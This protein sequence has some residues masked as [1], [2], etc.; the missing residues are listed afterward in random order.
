MMVAVLTTTLAITDKS[1]TFRQSPVRKFTSTVGYSPFQNIVVDQNSF[2]RSKAKHHEGSYHS[3][4]AKRLRQLG[5]ASDSAATPPGSDSVAIQRD[6][7][8]LIS[9]SIVFVPTRKPQICCTDIM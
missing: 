9:S 4:A 7:D 2:D 1:L 3:F 8:L 5:K 6:S